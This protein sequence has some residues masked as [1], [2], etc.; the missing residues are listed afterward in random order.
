MAAI[1]GMRGSGS[2]DSDSRP[3]NYR[4][5]ILRL[6]PHDK[7]PLMA[8]MSK[9]KNESVNDPEFKVFTKGLPTQV[10][11][12]SVAGYDNTSNPVAIP[13]DGT[14][15]QT[16][17]KPGHVVLN[18]TSGEVMWVTD[19][20]V[21][22]QVTVY[23]PHTKVAGLDNDLLLII[24]SAHEEGADTPGQ[25][26]Y[27]PAVVTNYT[28]IFRNSVA[29]TRTAKATRLRTGDQWKEAQKECLLLHNIEMEKAFFFGEAKEVLTGD[30]PKRTTKGIYKFITSNVLDYSAGLDIDTWENDLEDIF[31]YGSNQKLLICGARV[32]NA[33]NK[34]ARVNSQV[35]L[36]PES[37][38]YGM[39]IWS[40]VTPFGEIMMKIHPLFSENAVLNTWGFILD[41]EHL[42]YRYLEG[43]D[44]KYL[45]ARQGAGVDGI[46]D[47]YL[48]EAGLECRFEEVHAVIKG[49]SSVVA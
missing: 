12:V 45:K 32:I 41:L 4:E 6:F 5:L 47:E 28:Q 1:V 35:T 34:L 11:V 22:N 18:L 7:A 46:K 40:Y 10:A 27:D 19:A 39:R 25:I 21:A 3:K 44:T 14:N 42:V 33:M 36:V 49:L 9:L 24:G 23:R 8:L 2:W 31:R 38:T 16:F 30:Q 13:I 26:T 37:K 15:P 43:S 48:T 29:M 20:S 17:F